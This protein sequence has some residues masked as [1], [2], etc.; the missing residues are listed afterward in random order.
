MRKWLLDFGLLVALACVIEA[1]I[2][3]KVAAQLSPLQQLGKQIFFDQTLSNPPGMACATCHAPATGFTYPVSQ[4]NA[5]L[6]V[7]PGIVPGRF[8]NRKVPTVSYVA[9]SPA[10]P[11]FDPNFK[12]FVGGFFWD[13][14]A[15]TLAAQPAGPLFNPNEMNNLVNNVPA[16]ALVVNAIAKGPYANQFKR[17]F[18][19]NVFT[20]PPAQ[21][22]PLIGNALAAWES[23]TD[24]VPFTSK[25]DAWRAGLVQLNPSELNG[26]RLATGSTNGRPGGPPNVKSATCVQC[27]GIPAVPGAVPDLWSSY[28]FL[29]TGVPRNRNNPFYTQTNKLTNPLG[30][31]PLGANYIDLG[32]GDFLYPAKGLPIGNM[33]LGSNGLGDFLAI[34]GA[35]KVPTLRNT[36]KRP[37]PNFVKAYTHNGVFKSLLQVVHFYNTRNL[38]T[39]PGEVIDFTRPN[40]YAGLVGQPLWPPPEYPGSTLRNPTGAPG[41]IGNL[42]LTAQEEADIVA[43][44]GTLSDGAPAGAPAPPAPP[45]PPP[46][47]PQ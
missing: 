17:V 46:P 20:L 47:P 12:V 2:P 41:Q 7:A 14:R 19:A 4:I 1:C 32:L 29:N 23:S 35:F 8:G 42:G 30:Y 9:F 11:I 45:P 16:P 24:V 27:H 38:T 6:G 39:Q 22:I 10:G 26:L 37:A 36:D 28:R 44:L 15:N 33:G 25:Y 40:P 13:G 5:Q 34:N 21:V 43:F 3:A 18:G 31:N